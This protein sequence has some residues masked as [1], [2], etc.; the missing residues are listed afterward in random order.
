MNIKLTVFMLLSINFMIGINSVH[1]A[2][3]DV[4][5][6][7]LK[8]ETKIFFGGHQVGI[9]T[10]AISMGGAFVAIADDYTATY[11]NPAGLAQI[12]RMEML[13]SM[14][15]LMLD[16]KAEYSGQELV[17]ETTSTKF[18]SFGFVM[19]YP[20]YRGSL[21]FAFGYNNIGGFDRGLA[22]KRNVN[23]DV[24]TD[25]EESYYNEYT[26]IENGNFT[27]W[28]FSGALDVAKNLSMG[29]T[30]N[31]IRGKNDYQE[32]DY[33]D[34]LQN[35]LYFDYDSER[36][37]NTKYS[38]MSLKLGALYRL[39]ILGRLAATLTTPIKYKASENY[40]DKIEYFDNYDPIY[41]DYIE[42]DRSNSE[43]DYT[44]KV[45]YQFGVGAAFTL[46]PNLVVS[47]DI[48]Y[49][50]WSQMRY[51]TEPPDSGFSKADA[52]LL[53]KQE[54][55]ATA[56]IHAGAEFTVPFINM[57]LRAGFFNKPLPYKDATFSSDRK[58]LT[59]G[60][61]LLL[62]KQVKFDLAVLRG[63]WKDESYFSDDI[64]LLTENIEVTKFLAT[65]AVRF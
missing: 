41:E 14:S 22:I 36:N 60:V 63:W 53:I 37:I 35:I 56:E 12:Q 45:P 18:N 27:N 51:E 62:D 7:R 38:A 57:Q 30:I 25:T 16:T 33:F 17:D 13:G 1:S 40:K 54:Y 11:W 26:E 49:C 6:G 39:G 48:V 23:V 15:H 8:N 43:W 59:A 47:G 34:A 32:I 52:N 9:G 46:F 29:A 21:V 50:D 64:P 42:I 3:D 24:V 31:F 65:L 19:P 2:N 61:G 58:Y 4:N 5:L 44:I 28:A 20:T 55:R 10:K